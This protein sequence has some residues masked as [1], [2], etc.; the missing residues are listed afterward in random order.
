MLEKTPDSPLDTEEIKPVGLIGNQ[1]GIL[2]GRTDAEAPVF[3][4]WNANSQL[5]RK[6]SDA[7]KD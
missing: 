4:S 5:I 1:S 7:G 6:V 2:I 3:C